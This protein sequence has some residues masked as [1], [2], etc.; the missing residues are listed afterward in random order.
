MDC[1]IASNIQIQ[2]PASSVSEKARE[3]AGQTHGIGGVAPVNA[4]AKRCERVTKP[5]KTREPG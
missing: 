2:I 3:E 5:S 4:S 1:N